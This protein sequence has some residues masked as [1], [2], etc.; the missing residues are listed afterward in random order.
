VTRELPTEPGAVIGWSTWYDGPRFGGAVLDYAPDDSGDLMWY[1]ATGMQ[2]SPER[3][4]ELIPYWQYVG[5]IEP[6]RAA[7]NR[8]IAPTD[9][10]AGAEAGHSESSPPA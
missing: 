9:A 5:Q 2:W 1:L 4:A 10:D 8:P 3:L 6:P 7:G